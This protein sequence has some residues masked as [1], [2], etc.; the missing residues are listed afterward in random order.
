MSFKYYD[1]LTNLVPGLLIVAII[2]I[3]FG[4]KIP[5]VPDVILLALSFIVGYLNNTISSWLEDFYRFLW[6]GNP[7]SSFFNKT[8]I[9]KVPFYNGQE[10]KEILTK[11]AKKENLTHLQLFSDAMRVANENKTERLEDFNA[12]YAF[13]RA[14]L[15]AF[16]MAGTIFIY[17]HY[18]C[19]WA[20]FVV[21]TLIIVSLIRCKQRNGY[22]IR[23]VLNI[24]IQAHENKSA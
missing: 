17:A 11:R 6:G 18:Q 15:T 1:L 22:Y 21:I 23:E 3:C 14:L 13:S 4:D 19:L 10:V 5:H 2:Q 24:V 7:I 16:L 20:Y 12:S 8:G 9:F